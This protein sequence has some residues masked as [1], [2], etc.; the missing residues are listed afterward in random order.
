MTTPS[1]TRHGPRSAHRLTVAPGTTATLTLDSSFATPFLLA[2]ENRST[3]GPAAVATVRLSDAV[4]AIEFPLGVNEGGTVAAGAKAAVPFSA[5]VR[6]VV[7]TQHAD[8][9][10]PCVVEALQ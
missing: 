3:V 9:D 8:A 10:G 4:D 6:A 2:I 7:V 5:P 1:I